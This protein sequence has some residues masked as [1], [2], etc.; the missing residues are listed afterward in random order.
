M[1]KQKTAPYCKFCKLSATLLTP[2]QMKVNVYFGKGKV[3]RGERM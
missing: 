3:M 2:M 1:I